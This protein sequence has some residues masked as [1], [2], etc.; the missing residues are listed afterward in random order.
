MIK[1]ERVEVLV[2]SNP[3]ARSYVLYWMQAAK[4]T[5]YNHALEYAIDKANELDLPLIA[6]FGIDENFPGGNLR[7]FTFM[8]EGLKE[9]D[10]NL[11]RRGIELVVIKATPPD[12][13][14]KL[15]ENA[16][17]TVTDKGYLKINKTWNNRLAQKISC[18]LH[19]VETETIIPVEV[20]SSKEEYAAHTI[21][22][23]V[24]KNID[25]YLKPL[26]PRVLLNNSIRIDSISHIKK[27]D[28]KSYSPAS[29]ALELNIDKNIPPVKLYQGGEEHAEEKL[30]DFLSQKID[31]YPDKQN[32]PSLSITS[33]L[34]PYLHFGQISPLYVALKTREK[35]NVDIQHPFLEQL[36]VR[37]ELAV[38]FV[39]WNEYYDSIKS[40]PNWA[41][42]TLS[43]H[44]NDYREYLYSKDELENSRT[45]DDYFNAAMSELKHT[46]KIH[47]YMR[48][49][50]GKKIIEWTKTH[51]EAYNTLLDLNDR[52]GLDGRDP[53]GYTNILWCFGKHDR[54]FQE[55]K[56]FGKVR[57][58]SDKALKRNGNPDKY[59]LK[60]NNMISNS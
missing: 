60:I 11:K 4:R 30:N 49:Y 16:A 21:R 59:V 57:Y 54:P 40:L 47:N 35:A 41:L 8:L 56:I 44:D 19:V 55:R 23:K 58:M 37:R 12:G 33:D 43:K 27:V 20:L 6:Y 50:W 46:G 34:S 51:L 17:L 2:N 13:A 18:P 29:I 52:Y 14:A 36:I 48:M 24:Y 26:E 22:K 39:Y 9:V 3:V 15:A 28:L 38:N 31:Y 10:K 42:E 53:N 5:N 7:H 1:D 45:H 25:D 32:D